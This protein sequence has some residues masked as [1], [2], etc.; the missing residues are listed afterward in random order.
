MNE[1]FIVTGGLGFIGSNIVKKLHL[2]GR[3]SLIIDYR[4]NV[5][6][7]KN[8]TDC[9]ES[10]IDVIEPTS[11]QEVRAAVKKSDGVFHQ[12]ACAD[13]T[14]M[15]PRIML[16]QNHDFSVGLMYYCLEHQKKVVWAS[17][18]AVYGNSKDRSLK[19]LNIYGI[20]KLLTENHIRKAI[21]EGRAPL[22]TGLR[23]FNVYGPNEQHKGKM[24]SMVNQLIDQGSKN[25]QFVLFASGE[26]C[27]DFV[28]V[29]DVVD[30]NM[31]FMR[32]NEERCFGIFDVGTGRSR[33][34]NELTSIIEKRLGKV[35][36]TKYI[37]MPD[38]IRKFYQTNTVADLKPL[39]DT[40]YNQ[41]FLSLEEG[42]QKL[43]PE[44]SE[45]DI[46]E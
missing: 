40:G 35:I 38:E 31:H 28:H 32:S 16:N 46:A 15:D 4:D 45:G 24:M 19:P 18:A 43:L 5:D 44:I 13:T 17:S 34:F 10:V 25:S 22:I 23:Y 12:G 29:D 37:E 6:K 26:Q 20:S 7:F 11:I 42:V 14:L 27:R 41:K 8:I 3:R 21:V 36:D 39:R 2:T 30:V 1:F 33:S 9:L